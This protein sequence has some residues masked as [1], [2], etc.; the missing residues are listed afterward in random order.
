MI[1]PYEQTTDE[2]SLPNLLDSH[3]DSWGHDGC[4]CRR[5]IDSC[6]PKGA[7]VILRSARAP[8]R[9]PPATAPTCHFAV[10]HFL[11][12]R[13]LDSSPRQRNDI[14]ECRPPDM[15]DLTPNM[16]EERNT[17]HCVIR[18]NAQPV[19]FFVLCATTRLAST[20]SK[21]GFNLGDICCPYE[22][23]TLAMPITNAS[24]AKLKQETQYRSPNFEVLSRVKDRLQYHILEKVGFLWLQSHI[25]LR[26]DRATLNQTM[27][28]KLFLLPPKKHGYI[29]FSRPY[30][31]IE[32]KSLAVVV[33]CPFTLLEKKVSL[34]LS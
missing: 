8:P 23:E 29:A 14:T 27:L 20:Q 25:A 33:Y 26:I 16:Q 21:H 3:S 28:S 2:T 22:M 9:N 34:C 30:S 19:L 18:A 1:Y 7:S 13:V 5:L 15:H 32:R 6:L 24:H 4:K 11:E 31:D 12:I 17:R 10:F